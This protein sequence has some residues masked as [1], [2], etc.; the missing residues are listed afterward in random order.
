MYLYLQIQLN[1]KKCFFLLTH[2]LKSDPYHIFL[3]YLAKMLSLKHAEHTLKELFAT[4]RP[5]KNEKK[6]F[7]MLVPKSPNYKGF[8]VSK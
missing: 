3:A 1:K 6:K 7:F 2:R 8:V 4:K 5:N